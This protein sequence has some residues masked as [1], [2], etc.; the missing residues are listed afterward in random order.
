MVIGACPKLLMLAV[1]ELHHER[2]ENAD[3]FQCRHVVMD[4]GEGCVETVEEVID[5]RFGY[6]AGIRYAAKISVSHGSP[7]FGR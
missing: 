5:L 1:Q 4:A 2:V 6:A 7:F 3:P